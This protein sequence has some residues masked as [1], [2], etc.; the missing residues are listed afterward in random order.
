MMCASSSPRIDRGEEE[1]ALWVLAS[2]LFRHA[3]PG[4]LFGCWGW[5]KSSPEALK[6]CGGVSNAVYM[7]NICIQVRRALFVAALARPH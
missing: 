7:E 1:Q 5:W 4:R 2:A 3:S 6:V